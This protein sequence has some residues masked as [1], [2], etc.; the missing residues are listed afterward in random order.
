[1]GSRRILGWNTWSNSPNGASVDRWR[2]DR[3]TD[4]GNSWR[5]NWLDRGASHYWKHYSLSHRWIDWR[6]LEK[7][8]T[9]LTCFQR[10]V[11]WFGRYLVEP[12][13]F[14]WKFGCCSILL[15][16]Y[17]CICRRT[18]N[19]VQF[20]QDRDFVRRGISRDLVPDGTTL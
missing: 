11:D 9:I 6:S 17:V 3:R 8:L 12:S 5:S 15:G 2:C 10:E 14:C 1:V 7:R 19:F 18:R 13:S 4:W 16:C 20:H